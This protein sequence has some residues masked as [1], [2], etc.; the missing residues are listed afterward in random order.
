MRLFV[1]KDVTLRAVVKIA[2]FLYFLVY[3]DLEARILVGK[4]KESSPISR[5]MR[6][7]KDGNEGDEETVRY[8]HDVK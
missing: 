6:V 2:L 1:P 3:A 7:E 4:S 5:N 8:Y